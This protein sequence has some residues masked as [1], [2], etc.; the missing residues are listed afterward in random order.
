MA[1]RKCLKN[2]AHMYET[3]EEYQSHLVKQCARCNSK[4]WVHRKVGTPKNRRSPM[5]PTLL[6][7]AYFD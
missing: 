6:N 5:V 7:L 1:S 4:I 3:V 2:H